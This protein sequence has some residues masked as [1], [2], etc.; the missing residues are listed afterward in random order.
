MTHSNSMAKLRGQVSRLRFGVERRRVRAMQLDPAEVNEPDWKILRD[1]IWMSRVFIDSSTDLQHA[2]RSITAVRQCGAEVGGR[3]N[4]WTH[5]IPLSSKDQAEALAVTLLHR[6]RPNPDTVVTVLSRHEL[7]GIVL[8]GVSSLSAVEKST[9]GL[10]MTGR[11]FLVV[12]AVDNV[13]FGV[14]YACL[15]NGWTQENFVA[16]AQLQADK[17]RC[18]LAAI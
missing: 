18:Q 2:F 3:E 17:I 1:K 5:I 11:E 6:I 7:D 16:V 14:G 13:A 10:G 9:V 12:G 4:L 15:G 8:A